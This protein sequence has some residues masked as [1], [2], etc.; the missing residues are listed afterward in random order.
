MLPQ[1]LFINTTHGQL[2]SASEKAK[3]VI[4]L[5]EMFTVASQPHYTTAL[6]LQQAGRGPV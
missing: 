1:V 2:T 4:T 5:A 6:Q 3:S